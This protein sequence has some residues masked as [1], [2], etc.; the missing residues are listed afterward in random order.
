MTHEVCIFWTFC[1]IR[2]AERSRSCKHYH[3]TLFQHHKEYRL[4]ENG[5]TAQL[6]IKIHYIVI[7]LYSK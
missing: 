4:L 7:I 2:S 6:V 3:S 5:K 1:L